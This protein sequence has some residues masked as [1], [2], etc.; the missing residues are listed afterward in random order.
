M[1]WTPDEFW[2]ST[3]TDCLI[4]WQVFA[5][6]RDGAV[7]SEWQRTQWAVQILG[8]LHVEKKDMSK[9]RNATALPWDENRRRNRPAITPEEVRRQMEES[10]RLARKITLNGS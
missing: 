7:R 3:L 4:A 2:D 10:A 1:G 6:E 9:F 8:A 5:E